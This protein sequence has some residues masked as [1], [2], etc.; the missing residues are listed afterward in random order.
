MVK[1]PKY[2]VTVCAICNLSVPAV[3]SVIT[4]GAATEDTTAPAALTANTK[5]SVPV[6]PVK[7]STPTPPVNVSLPAPPINVS[8]PVP[9][10]NASAPAPVVN[11]KPAVAM[12][13][14]FVTAPLTAEA[15]T[16][17][18]ATPPPV[19]VIAAVPEE[20]TFIL[21]KLAL[22]TPKERAVVSVLACKLLMVAVSIK[23]AVTAAAVPAPV[24]PVPEAAPTFTVIASAEPVQPVVLVTVAAPPV[25][26]FT[27]P[28]AAK[29]VKVPPPA[30]AMV[31]VDTVLVDGNAT[32]TP[33][34]MRTVSNP[35]MFAPV[36]VEIATDVD[37]VSVPSPP[38]MVCVA[39]IEEMFTRSLPAPVLMLNS[40]EPP[41]VMVKVSAPSPPVTVPTTVPEAPLRVATMADAPAPVI[42]KVCN[43]SSVIVNAVEEEPVAPA[44]FT[45]TV[46]KPLTVNV[47]EVVVLAPFKVSV[48]ASA[49][50]ATAAA[51]WVMVV[52][53]FAPDKLTATFAAKPV[54]VTSAPVE[55]ELV[56]A[57]MPV[58][59]VASRLKAPPVAVIDTVSKPVAVTPVPAAKAE[60][61]VMLKV[62]LPAPPL[63]LSPEFRVWL[64]EVLTDVYVSSPLPAVRRSTPV[65]SVK[66][67]LG[68]AAETATY[69]PVA[70]PEVWDKACEFA[71]FW[72]KV[73]TDAP[74]VASVVDMLE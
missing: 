71:T 66:G 50:P 54:T 63:M 6:P 38:A 52:L 21:V 7:R 47:P 49:V 9:P 65:V 1:V 58:I 25:V 27:V 53:A 14:L 73:I 43:E 5:V 57:V 70:V 11:E 8:A 33:P 16:V 10:V 18:N 35:E 26:R 72:L 44:A 55:P 29:L 17:V 61:E 56:I 59:V 31:T 12:V 42:A 40:P 51:A 46:S 32:V 69:V 41:G 48:K 20:T 2:A 68:V 34:A 60:V 67:K 28:L 62:S 3:K 37:K 36:V 30:S 39:A 15:S 23:V 22:V 19:M 45:F 4:S 13:A 24:E 74:Y 64:V